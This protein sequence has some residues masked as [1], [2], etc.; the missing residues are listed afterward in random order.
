MKKG[1]AVFKIHVLSLKY[2]CTPSANPILVSLG[3]KYVCKASEY[4]KY[5]SLVHKYMCTPCKIFLIRIKKMPAHHERIENQS[6]LVSNMSAHLVRI[7]N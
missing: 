4:R 7:E 2:V 3:L 6:N 5:V 1:L